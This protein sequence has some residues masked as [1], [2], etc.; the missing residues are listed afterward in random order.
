[1]ATE[2]ERFSYD[3]TITVDGF[4]FDSIVPPYYKKDAILI[5]NPELYT[6]YV[7]YI[8]QK[9]LTQA[10][11]NTHSLK[12]LRDCPSLS[13]IK[14]FPFDRS[15]DFYDFSPLYE[16]KL[17]YLHCSCITING[18][19]KKGTKFGEI[20]FSKM[21]GLEAL[22][23]DTSK[24]AINYNTIETLKTLS[25]YHYKS[26]SGDLSNLFCSTQLD[27]LRL[28][29]SSVYSLEG[30]EQTQKLQCLDLTYNRQLEDISALKKVKNSLKALHICCCAKI[31]DFSVFYELENLEHLRIWGSNTLPSLDF[32]KYLP[33]LQS[34]FLFNTVADGDLTPL[35]RMRYAQVRN[36]RHYNLKNKDLPKIRSALNGRESIEEWRRLHW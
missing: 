16:R 11:I 7:N 12:I 28:F 2:I 29:F 27:S 20:D 22:F 26:S 34:V 8:R 35:L 24:G 25:A 18:Y 3:P 36:K 9:E 13:Y 31:K 5:S 14:L 6:N 30:I 17:H 4:T 23:L 15:P 10:V 32:V 1:M 19:G 33:N 21:Q